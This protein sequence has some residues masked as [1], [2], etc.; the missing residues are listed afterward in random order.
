[1]EG[2]AAEKGKSCGVLLVFDVGSSSVRLSAM[3]AETLSL[4]QHVT[5]RDV[6]DE[7]VM[8]LFDV[9]RSDNLS[10]LMSRCDALLAELMERLMEDKERRMKVEGIGFTGFVMNL[11]GVKLVERSGGWKQ[12]T[13]LFTYANRSMMDVV[14]T[15]WF[16]RFLKQ[17]EEMIETLK[18]YLGTCFLHK[19]YAFVQLLQWLSTMDMEDI[20]QVDCFCTISQL[21]VNRYCGATGI[22]CRVISLSEASWTGL[23][24]HRLLRWEPRVFHLLGRAVACSGTGQTGGSIGEI[25]LHK[26]PEPRSKLDT[27]L[28][29]QPRNHSPSKTLG[30]F[31][32]C[33]RSAKLFL[34]V[35]DGYAAN[36][37]THCVGRNNI[38]ITIGT[39]AAVRMLVRKQHLL[40]RVPAGLFCYPVTAEYCLVGGALTDGGSLIAWFKQTFVCGLVQYLHT[41]EGTAF[42]SDLKKAQVADETMK[43]IETAAMQLDPVAASLKL[44]PFLNCERS[45]GWNDHVSLSIT[46]I[47]SSTTLPSIYRAVIEGLCFRLKTIVEALLSQCGDET[48]STVRFV[49]SGGAL[50]SSALLQAILSDALGTDLYHY[51]QN[52]RQASIYG[53]ALLIQQALRRAVSLDFVDADFQESSTTQYKLLKETNPELHDTYIRAYGEHGAFYALLS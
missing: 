2:A 25:L 22:E 14:E 19:S 26:F 16:S 18:K 33:L 1:M 40:N 31:S 35:A 41:G 30:R 39:S 29:F 24:N 44:L 23:L 48:D 47:T 28:T 5:Y 45:T 43:C 3:E 34:G 6:D 20:L 38:C 12:L 42:G 7:A 49:A 50:E 32:G 10:Y 11:V 9:S 13:P 37:G 46:G 15:D 8:N 52:H 4:I 51:D 53:T 21:L 36:V 27:G 17:E